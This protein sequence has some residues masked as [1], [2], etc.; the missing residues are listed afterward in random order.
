MKM[1]SFINYKGI[2][3]N[4]IRNINLKLEKQKIIGISG[5]SGSGKTSLAYDTIYQISKYE[6]DK[7]DNKAHSIKK[8]LIEE[9][10][11]IIPALTLLQ[12]N[13]NNNPRSTLATYLTLDDEF[14][15]IFAIMNFR[16]PSEF[17]FNNYKNA[18]L[19][20]EGTGIGFE[21]DQEKIIDKNKKIKDG[22]F[23]PWTKFTSNHYEKLLVLHSSEI[24][25]SIDKKY[26][27]LD[28]T[29]K[30]ELL[31]GISDKKYTISYKQNGKSRRKEFKYIGLMLEL[32]KY[33]KDIKKPSNKIKINNYSKETVCPVC[34][35]MR[36]NAE[37]L[38]YKV[39]LK[40][41]GELY[42]MEITELLDFLKN[43]PKC[44]IIE[45]GINPFVDRIIEIL[46]Y[47]DES[48]LGYL[49]L[50]R[51][52]PTLSGGE[53]QRIRITN[54]IQ[55][56]LS[57]ILYVIDEP[58]A[59][60]HVSEYNSI[61]NSLQIIKNRGN[62]IIMVEH[63]RNFLKLCD[64]IIFL[65]PGAGKDGGF[66]VKKDENIDNIIFPK[67]NIFGYYNEKKLNK[68]NLK[69][70]DIQFPKNALTG[71]YGPSG[72]GKT[73]LVKELVNRISRSEYVTQKPISGNI[74]STIASYIGIY[75]EIRELFSKINKVD[76]NIFSFMSDTGKCPDCDGKGLIRYKL[77]F[78]EEIEEIICDKC[79]GKRYNDIALKY[80]YNELNIYEILSLTVNE[81]IEG[82]LFKNISINNKL[83][84][85]EQIGLGYLSLFRTTDTL[86]GGEAQRIRLTKYI[87]KNLNDKILF[88]DEPLSGLSERDSNRLLL[89]LKNLILNNNAT[90][91]FIE[92]NLIGLKAIDYVIEI[93]PG[94][95]L[96]G[97]EVIFFGEIKDF[98]DSKNF[99]KYKKY[100]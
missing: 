58:S 75:D 10:N 59:K 7:I 2:K 33:L 28:D 24:G 98:Y 53:L 71:I 99:K 41:L 48:N 23:I 45:N 73:S 49:N 4:N 67:L 79:N 30:R 31:Y 6:F 40:N 62:T 11:G 22:A 13:K 51:S 63:N 80:K 65:G 19:E 86:S 29:E 34:S 12:N 38:K 90:I 18:C 1:G 83:N 55:S 9:Y 96:N 100:I 5:P 81:L 76:K 47:I 50:N 17:S 66:I 92:H 3:T 72:S 64:E 60:L 25:I 82:K 56:K 93:G 88:L 26:D 54:I 89:L 15:I 61:Q 27:D 95:G 43:I 77:G 35:G 46:E 74:N 84:I 85:L 42:M 37:V 8:F 87:G 52:I 94:K 21:L 44:E 68:N 91:L 69:N 39:F 36:F 97:G 70:I 14:K 16:D 20:C 32:E 78:S 57:D